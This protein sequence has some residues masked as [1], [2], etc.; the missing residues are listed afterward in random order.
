MMSLAKRRD[1]LATWAALH[2]VRDSL[3]GDLARESRRWREAITHDDEFMS[4]AN[5]V[6]RNFLI[7]TPLAG[8]Q[9]VRRIVKFSYNEQRVNPSFRVAARDSLRRARRASD[10]AGSSGHGGTG[11]MMGAYWS[12]LERFFGLRAKYVDVPA[13]SVARAQCFHLEVIVPEGI[14]LTRGKLLGYSPEE[15][16][17]GG[18]DVGQA[19]AE[20]PMPGSGSA[21]SH[22]IE[23]AAPLQEAHTDVI[24]ASTECAHLHV[25]DVPRTFTGVGVVA[26]RMRDELVLRGVW[27]NGVFTAAIL[28]LVAAFLKSF[29]LH[30]DATVA[31]LLGVSGGVSLYLAR[32]REP[33]MSAAMHSGVRLLALGNALTAFTAIAVVLAGGKCKSIAKTNEQLCTTSG[34][35]KPWLIALAVLAGLMLA[36]LSLALVYSRK[37]PEQRGA[38]RRRTGTEGFG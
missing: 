16:V 25:A 21:G 36:I 14:W 7:L 33:G 27:I 18:Q 38:L 22:P 28:C 30:V 1:A 2:R 11:S 34:A 3:T 17:P 37:P 20:A 15:V 4:L 13:S 29:E 32:P 5:D 26:L 12:E 31:V 19:L 9:G 8:A 24:V 35:T 6:A 10:S 23:L